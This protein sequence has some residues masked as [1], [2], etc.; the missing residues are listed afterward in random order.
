MALLPVLV[1]KKL[2][3]QIQ[4]WKNIFF[5]ILPI[6]VPLKD[7]GFYPY[8]LAVILRLFKHGVHY[9]GVWVSDDY[10]RKWLLGAQTDLTKSRWI[11]GYQGP[12][13]SV[14]AYAV[15]I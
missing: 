10:H 9:C 3:P 12:M 11:Q 8:A 6:P 7:E 5:P 13:F 1:G 2:S 15:G 4:S 14:Y